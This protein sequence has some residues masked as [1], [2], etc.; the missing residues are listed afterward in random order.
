MVG[1]VGPGGPEGRRREQPPSSRE[2]TRYPTGKKDLSFLL[3]LWLEVYSQQ[4]E[5]IPGP[6]GSRRCRNQARK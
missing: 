6:Q 1:K 4:V 5:E 3:W 2:P